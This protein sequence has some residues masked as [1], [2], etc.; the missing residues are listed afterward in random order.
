MVL[1]GSTCHYY[2]NRALVGSISSN[3]PTGSMCPYVSVQNTSGAVR[4]VVVDRVRIWVS[5]SSLEQ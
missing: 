5:A 3:F 4:S 2:L 1:D